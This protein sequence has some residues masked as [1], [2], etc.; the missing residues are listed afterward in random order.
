MSIAGFNSSIW[1]ALYVLVPVGASVFAIAATQVNWKAGYFFDPKHNGIGHE[2]AGDFGPHLQ[3]YQDLAKL[4]ITLSTGAIAFLINTLI[5]Q[6]EPLS[7]MASKA[8]QTGPI[9]TGFF[10]AAISLLI[11][12]MVVQTVWYEEYSHS[13]KHN[14]YAAWKYCVSTTLGYTGLLSFVLGFIWLAHNLFR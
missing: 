1:N 6:K 10:G 14:T 12:F 2:N 13:M 7:P 8:V 11:G 9:V 4:V 5:N 3:R